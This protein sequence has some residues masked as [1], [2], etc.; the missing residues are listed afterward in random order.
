M[1]SD[2]RIIEQTA[3]LNVELSKNQQF[4]AE[5][6]LLSPQRGISIRG[7]GNADDCKLLRLQNASDEQRW[8]LRERY[9][10]GRDLIAVYPHS[11]GREIETC[12]YWRVLSA[13][14]F[15][16]EADAPEVFLGGFDIIVSLQTDLPHDA[17]Y[18][19]IGSQLSAAELWRLPAS[20]EGSE[21]ICQITS[22]EMNVAAG[23]VVF[24]L[25]SSQLSYAE[26]THPASV[27]Q[28]C[29]TTQGQTRRTEYLLSEDAMEK[30]VIRQIRIRGL[31]LPRQ[32]DL[33]LVQQYY[34][35][36]LTSEPPLTV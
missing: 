24:R 9:A 20:G 13:D 3:S 11:T 4:S 18:L 22:S 32:H 19:K 29:V 21:A 30:G 28:S 17:P 2:W 31:W 35:H 16:P 10:R 5:V 14:D 12:V 15:S 1:A 23:A 27:S 25:P 8:Q 36:W 34:E 7:L 26:F 6:D 33:K